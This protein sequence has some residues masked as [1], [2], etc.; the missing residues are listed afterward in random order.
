MARGESGLARIV[1]LA[2]LGEAVLEVTKESGLLRRKP[3]RKRRR[4]IE[5]DTDQLRVGKAPRP[6]KKKRVVAKKKQRPV[7]EPVEDEVEDEDIEEEEE[8]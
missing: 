4:E 7:V 6:K 3:G 5:E 2:Q 1:T 8:D